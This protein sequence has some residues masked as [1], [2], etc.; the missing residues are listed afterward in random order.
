MHDNLQIIMDSTQ[1]KLHVHKHAVPVVPILGMCPKLELYDS[2]A[3]SIA[4]KHVYNMKTIIDSIQM[5]LRFHVKRYAI[6]VVLFL[7]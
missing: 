5:R 6:L 3:Y 2:V 1:M 7:V 4:H